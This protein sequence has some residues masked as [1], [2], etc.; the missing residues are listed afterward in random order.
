MIKRKFHTLNKISKLNLFHMKK[1]LSFLLL[2]TCL[3]L[4][5][6]TSAQSFTKGQKNFSVGVG[7]GYGLGATAAVDYGITDMVSIG[8]VGGY[9]SRNYGYILSNYRVNYIGLAGRAAIHFGKYLKEIGINEAKLDPYVGVVGGFRMVNYSDAYSSYYN[10]RNA[11]II[12]GG[13]LGARYYLK[14]KV[15]LYAEAGV[16]YSTIGLSVKF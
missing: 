2:V 14:E 16:P 15:A 13:I 5:R 1:N 6:N 9:S 8:V 3:F 7:V 10:G 12:L 11:G 4:F